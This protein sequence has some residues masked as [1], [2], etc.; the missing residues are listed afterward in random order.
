LLVKSPDTANKRNY[1][2][3]SPPDVRS[4]KYEG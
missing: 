4:E 3:Y 1:A 2:D